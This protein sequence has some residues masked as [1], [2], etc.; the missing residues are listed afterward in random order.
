MAY[1]TDHCDCG[2][3]PNSHT[4]S[5]LAAEESDESISDVI[6]ALKDESSHLM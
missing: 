1:L 5:Q 2:V 3:E 4:E 6:G